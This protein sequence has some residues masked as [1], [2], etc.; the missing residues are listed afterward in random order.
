[1]SWRASMPV[2]VAAMVVR[3]RSLGVI[4]IISDGFGLQVENFRRRQRRGRGRG[5]GAPR[6]GRAS[7]H[8][9]STLEQ[10]VAPHR[11]TE[12]HLRG[13]RKP[14]R[15]GHAAPGFGVAAAVAR[16]QPLPSRPLAR[17]L[18]VALFFGFFEALCFGRLQREGCYYVNVCVAMCAL[19]R[20]SWV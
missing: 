9:N 10:L 5:W 7:P 19:R 11:G 3:K 1:L 8:T 17:S 4:L 2:F 15:D 14:A 13:R 12:R 20:K 18:A 16:R 6:R